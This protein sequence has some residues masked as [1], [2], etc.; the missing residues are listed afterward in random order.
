[1]V[2]KYNF[3]WPFFPYEYKFQMFNALTPASCTNR[4]K[5]SSLAQIA[6]L[7]LGGN[8]KVSN[9]YIQL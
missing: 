6:T 7:F 4:I 1:M 2:E 9:V 8:I 3:L 5:L